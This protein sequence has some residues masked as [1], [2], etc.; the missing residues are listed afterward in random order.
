MKNIIKIVKGFGIIFGIWLVWNVS[1]MSAQAAEQQEDYVV[2]DTKAAV[3]NDDI[4]KV[5]YYDLKDPIDDKVIV[6]VKMYI[7]Y[8]YGDCSWVNVS[9][10]KINVYWCNGYKVSVS[11]DKE[12]LNSGDRAC[13]IRHMYIQNVSTGVI[14]HY[15]VCG[16]AD[17]YGEVDITCILVE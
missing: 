2:F 3:T 14:K 5:M 12:F 10:A 13:C 9:D 6:E 4:E 16:W 15:K 8:T 7:Y 1:G 11:E 17:Y